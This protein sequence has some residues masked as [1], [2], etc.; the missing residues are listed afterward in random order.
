MI[1][2]SKN[3]HI[4]FPE[5]S[6]CVEC[7]KPAEVYHHI[8][9][10]SRGGRSA[11]PLCGDCHRAAHGILGN[12]SSQLIKEGQQ[13]AR[14]KGKRIGA[15]RKLSR[16]RELE[17]FNDWYQSKMSQRELANK[18]AVTPTMIHRVLR[19]IEKEATPGVGGYNRRGSSK[20]T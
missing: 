1:V 10:Y 6:A 17:I 20:R 19:S 4:E 16:E 14:E 18:Y 2:H 8:I 15:P 13:R 3:R 11:V 9:P 7:Q 12:W 5:H